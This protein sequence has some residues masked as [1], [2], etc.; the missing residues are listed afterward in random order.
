MSH[1]TV[2]EPSSLEMSPSPHPEVNHTLTF[3][4]IISVTIHVCISKQIELGLPV[5]ELY[6]NGIS[7]YVLYD[8]LSLAVSQGQPWRFIPRNIHWTLSTAL[9]V[10]CFD[11]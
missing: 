4:I 10:Y 9:D 11:L 7:L 6:T 8:D 3:V 2:S 5:F 1:V